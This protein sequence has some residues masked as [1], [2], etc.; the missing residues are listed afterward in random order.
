MRQIPVVF[1]F[2]GNSV[3]AAPD[4]FILCQSSHDDQLYHVK[5]AFHAFNDRH[6]SLCENDTI[7]GT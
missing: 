2:K 5:E 1:G 7:L 6:S 3:S 4:W